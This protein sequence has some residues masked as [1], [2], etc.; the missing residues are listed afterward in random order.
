TSSQTDLQKARSDLAKA[1]NDLTT[2]NQDKQ[3]LTT[4]LKALTAASAETDPAKQQQLAQ[5]SQ[6]ACA[7]GFQLAGIKTS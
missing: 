7:H 1:Q 3:S 2:A 5:Q 6:Q 4:C